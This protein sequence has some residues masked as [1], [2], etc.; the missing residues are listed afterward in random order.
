MSCLG[1]DGLMENGLLLFPDYV[2]KSLDVCGDVDYSTL[3]SRNLLD[4]RCALNR[5]K[6]GDNWQDQHEPLVPFS[7]RN[8]LRLQPAL[9]TI[10]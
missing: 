3:A 10:M 9:E 8:P 6:L 1:K 4:S 7:D 2:Q 5:E